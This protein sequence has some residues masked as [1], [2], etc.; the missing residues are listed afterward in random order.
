MFQQFF[1]NL[2]AQNDLFLA[3]LVLA[4]AVFGFLLAQ[5]LLPRFSRP[6][7]KVG[8]AVALSVLYMLGVIGF[9]FVKGAYD[10]SQLLG[11]EVEPARLGAI[12]TGGYVLALILGFGF[13]LSARARSLSICGRGGYAFVALIPGLNVAFAAWKPNGLFLNDNPPVW[14]KTLLGIG[15][16]SLLGV[17]A[18][19]MLDPTLLEFEGFGD[20]ADYDSEEA[21]NQARDYAE[22]IEKSNLGD[23]L[24][25]FAGGYEEGYWLDD[26][27]YLR[28]VTSNNVDLQFLYE[29]EIEAENGFQGEISLTDIWFLRS[30]CDDPSVMVFLAAGVQLQ[31]KFVRPDRSE[32]GS[33]TV[34]LK[35]CQLAVGNPA[36]QQVAENSAPSPQF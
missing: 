30:D 7:H 10:A 24:W 23:T 3:G 35:D 2:A 32:I 36:Q 22:M 21:E 31:H 26:G 33:L 19:S 12:Y 18:T 11:A 13:G 6:L 5:V 1:S 25:R 4:I 14:Y 8:F 17:A 9:L 16:A 15:T 29:V 20:Y 34:T 27:V 28:D